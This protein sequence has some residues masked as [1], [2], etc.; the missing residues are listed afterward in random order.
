MTKLDS[1]VAYDYLN[2]LEAVAQKRSVESVGELSWGY[3]AGYV[4]GNLSQT[5]EEL[6]LS[7]KQL[8]IL[9]EKTENFKKSD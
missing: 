7:Q 4:S 8:K 6:N 2:A 5:L 3:V 1:T 9:K